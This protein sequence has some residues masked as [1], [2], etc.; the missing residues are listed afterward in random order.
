MNRYLRGDV[1][2]RGFQDWFIREAW[3]LG[4]SVDPSL[5]SVVMDIELRLAEYTNG[6]LTE[7]ELA[8][9]FRALLD[10]FDEFRQ[11]AAG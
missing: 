10:R 11:S 2:L 9:A 3:N 5:R 6:H 4:P 1:S 8:A 7:P